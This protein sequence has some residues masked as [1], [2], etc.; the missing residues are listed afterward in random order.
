[1]WGGAMADTFFFLARIASLEGTSSNLSVIFWIHI[2]IHI[3]DEIYQK[4][5][6]QNIPN[7][8]NC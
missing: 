2:W 3:S 4:Y 6:V 8:Q 5:E 1:M 7:P